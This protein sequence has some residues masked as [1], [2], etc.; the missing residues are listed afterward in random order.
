MIDELDYIIGGYGKPNPVFIYSLNT[1][2]EAFILNSS[3]YIATQELM[4]IQIISKSI[5]PNG[6]PILELLS[7]TKSLSAIGGIGNDIGQV[8]SIGKFDVNNP[9][10]YQERIKDFIDNG[11]ETNEARNKYLVISTIEEIP[12]KLSYLNIGKV[13]DGFVATVSF[14]TPQEFYKKFNNITKE[15]NVQATLPF[16]SY[17]Y[18]IDEIQKR[19]IGREIITNLSDTFNNRLN[20]INQYFGYTNQILPPL[21]TILLSQC[22]DISD[23][24]L[25]AIQL[26]ED[27]SLLRS[28]IVKYE[29]RI[30]EANNIKDQLE[31]IDE[32]NEFWNVFNKKYSENQRLL[33]QFWELTEDSNCEKSID[34]ALDT[35][36]IS[37]IVE[38]LNAGKV[39]GKGAKKILSWYKDRKI[40]NRF[41]GVTD[42]WNLF[43][44]SPNI[45]KHLSEYE[46]VFN[47][48]V[49]PLDLNALNERIHQIRFKTSNE[50]NASR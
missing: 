31:A 12:T 21:V 8:I 18:Q 3:F 14:N 35:G 2:L 16:Y 30:N 33:Y 25:K 5:F 47:V 39:I 27:F 48:K 13:E 46:R 34:N 17:K 40:I 28:S 29:V 23:I 24:P 36:D 11:F 4:H 41:R 50:K 9:T 1:F 44:K 19:G 37:N 15:T 22:K 7:N 10:S 20:K 32:L 43:E 49:D 6:R 26:R 42:I 45:K 38:D